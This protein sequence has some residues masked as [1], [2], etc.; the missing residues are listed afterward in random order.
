MR[1][2]LN[3]RQRILY[4]LGEKIVLGHYL[5]GSVLPREQDLA[6]HYKVSRTV[7]REAVKGLAARGLLTSR[8]NVGATVNPRS[9]WQWIDS[10]V[11]AWSLVNRENRAD[12]LLSL[13]EAFAVVN[14]AVIED[15]ALHCTPDELERVWAAYACLETSQGNIDDWDKAIDAWYTVLH[16]ICRNLMLQSI[17]LRLS[18]IFKSNLRDLTASKLA[19]S[20]PHISLPWTHS[21]AE[22][23]KHHRQICQC[24]ELHDSDMAFLV[25]RKIFQAVLNNIRILRSDPQVRQLIE[26]AL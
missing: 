26:S 9:E 21:S 17:A 7:I 10:D 23:L 24:I 20:A 13:Y 19:R 8:P 25:A 11:I 2:H 12:V 18:E 16:G 14:P 15:V 5:P 22:A 4:D 3:L 1:R 6:E